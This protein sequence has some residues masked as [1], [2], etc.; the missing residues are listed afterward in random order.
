MAAIYKQPEECADLAVKIFTWVAK[1]RRILKVNEIQTAV[2][3][4]Q[5]RYGLLF[6]NG[7]FT[8]FSC[9]S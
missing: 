7:L 8:T 2:S 3:V 6:F 5:G 4:K 9:H 1:A